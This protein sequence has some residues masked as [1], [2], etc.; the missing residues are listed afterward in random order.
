MSLASWACRSSCAGT[1]C[2]R[3][4]TLPR[5]VRR[6][7]VDVVPDIRAAPTTWPRREARLL[8]QRVARRADSCTGG[9]RDYRAAEVRFEISPRAGCSGDWVLEADDRAHAGEQLLNAKRLHQVV[10]GRDWSRPF[11][12]S[13]AGRR[14][15]GSD[16]RPLLRARS[17][18]Q[19]AEQF[20]LRQ[21]D[22]ADDRANARPAPG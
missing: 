4:A 7:V 11:T 22:V 17:G 21:H 18:D 15:V 2:T 20:E 12:R 6:E 10:V 5:G 1:R 9:R 13:P 14:A 19:Q 16:R 8:E 3:R